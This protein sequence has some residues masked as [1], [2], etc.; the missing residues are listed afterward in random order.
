MSYE[1]WKNW[2]TWNV[3]LWFGN[4]RGL[5]E[6]VREHETGTKSNKFTAASAKDF[7]LELLPNG[8]PDMKDLTPGQLHSAYGKVSWSEIA[9]DFNEMRED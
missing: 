2:E 8:T 5:Y 6:T 4:D 1:G 9:S 3:A 7:V